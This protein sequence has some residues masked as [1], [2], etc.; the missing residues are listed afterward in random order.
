MFARPAEP[1]IAECIMAGR[2]IPNPPF[3]FDA[4]EAA[5]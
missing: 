2:V 4:V 1:A 3:I 5:G